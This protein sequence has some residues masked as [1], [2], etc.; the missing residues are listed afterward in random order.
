M[1]EKKQ[2]IN[3]ETQESRG[4][5]RPFAESNVPRAEE[6][7]QYQSYVLYRNEDEV[8]R[9]GGKRGREERE[10]KERDGKEFNSEINQVVYQTE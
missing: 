6:K 1:K 3:S 10:K 4:P 5:K 8:K 2:T 7:K 9:T